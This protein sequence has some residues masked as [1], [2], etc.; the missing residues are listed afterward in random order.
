MAK[1]KEM[2]FWI[3][4]ADEEMSSAI[5]DHLEAVGYCTTDARRFTKTCCI[6]Q[7]A[8]NGRVSTYSFIDHSLFHDISGEEIN[9]DW[10]RTT[11]PETVEPTVLEGPGLTKEAALE[12]ISDLQSYIEELDKPKR[13][14]V[15]IKE[16]AGHGTW[17]V[18]GYMNYLRGTVQDAIEST[19]G[20]GAVVRN[21]G[22]QSGYSTWNLRPDDFVVVEGSL[23]D[24]I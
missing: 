1:F 9:I 7:V 24:L 20:G 10:M 2:K 14:R 23:E 18:K 12:Q 11:K 4:V 21:T 6:I 17:N 15:Y 8:A 3:G 13:V 22:G 19:G 5:I 16:D